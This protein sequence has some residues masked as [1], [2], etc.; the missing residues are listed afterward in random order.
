MC[1]QGCLVIDWLKRQR[2]LRYQNA[3]RVVSHAATQRSR[4]LP[5]PLDIGGQHRHDRQGGCAGFD[6]N[7][8]GSQVNV[9][10]CANKIVQT[11][12]RHA[13]RMCRCIRFQLDN[14]LSMFQFVAQRS[15]EIFRC[16]IGQVLNNV[17]GLRQTAGSLYATHIGRETGQGTRVRD[18]T[19]ILLAIQR[20]NGQSLVSHFFQGF[21]ECRAIKRFTCG[22]VPFLIVWKRKLVKGWTIILN[23]L[24]RH[25]FMTPI[26][27]SITP[28]DQGAISVYLNTAFARTM[29]A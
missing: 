12:Q 18:G 10:K 23:I 16:Q 6:D 4:G 15:V 1:E 17:P 29:L 14:G 19:G 13:T 9:I 5:L 28:R 22:G 8:E 27:R 26:E 2:A 3:N 7:R 21:F 20:L 11:V 25:Q 24:F